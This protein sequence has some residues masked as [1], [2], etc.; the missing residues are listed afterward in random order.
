MRRWFGWPSVVAAILPA[1]MMATLSVLHHMTDFSPQRDYLRSE[2]AKLDA[3][4]GDVNELRPII[5]EFLA[6]K[7]IIETLERD[8]N[9]GLRLLNEVSL[10]RPDGVRFVSI[11][12]VRG[13]L[14]VEGVAASEQAL[15]NFTSAVAASSV[16]QAPE[17]LVRR[18]L[19]FSF[20]T[21][22][23]AVKEQ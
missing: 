7:Q 19:D 1:I 15:R 10:R 20:Q 22:L 16:L 5:A 4:L 3:E 18:G 8:R 11:S 9:D 17:G 21:G 6:R 2:I 13:R 14:I 12:F 23:R